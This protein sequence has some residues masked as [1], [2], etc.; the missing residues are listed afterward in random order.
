MLVCHCNGVSDKRIRRIVR[1]GAQ[2]IDA[3][4]KSDNLLL[5][6]KAEIDTKPEL[7]IYA[8]DVKCSHGATVGELDENHLFYL[9]ARGLDEQ[10]ARGL[11][12][13]AFANAL[14]AR[15]A[16]PALRERAATRLAGQLPETF[17]LDEQLQ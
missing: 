14:I 9:R 17:E 12:T 1:E 15:I 7:E 11:L 13:F 2:K 3:S 8:D 5:S 10:A 6:D 16:L 4:Q